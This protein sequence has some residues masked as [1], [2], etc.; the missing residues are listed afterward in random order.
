M[1]HD[2]KLKRW[3]WGLRDLTDGDITVL[4]DTLQF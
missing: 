3:G 1:G 4:V 2:H